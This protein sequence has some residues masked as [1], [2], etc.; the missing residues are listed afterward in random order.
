MSR[1]A[2]R[3]KIIYEE[4]MIYH[5]DLFPDWRICQLMENFRRWL[6]VNKGINDMFYLEDDRFI[7]LFEEFIWSIKG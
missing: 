7:K 2:N 6:Q 3:L 4:L 5:R 1:D